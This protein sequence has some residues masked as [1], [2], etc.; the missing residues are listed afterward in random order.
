ML[1][2]FLLK[3][4]VGDDCWEIDHKKMLLFIV[5]EEI[6]LASYSPLAAW[7]RPVWG[8]V[9]GFVEQH[10]PRRHQNTQ[11]R[12]HTWGNIALSFLSFQ[13]IFGQN[14]FKYFISNPKFSKVEVSVVIK[15]SFR[16]NGPQGLLVWGAHN[17]ETPS[18]KVIIVL[19]V[20]GDVALVDWWN[21][22][23]HFLE[24]WKTQTFLPYWWTIQIFQYK[25]ISQKRTVVERANL[26][27]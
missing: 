2:I 27:C 20:V 18:S 12:C 13:F 21:H 19:I 9:G 6:L 8:G 26:S 22:F 1:F 23:W 25:A 14:V 5:D 11:D 3:S 10:H 24:T 4:V 7:A 16:H 17:E 15:F